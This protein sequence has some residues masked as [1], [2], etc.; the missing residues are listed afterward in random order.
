MYV[1][2]REYIDIPVDPSLA[3]KRKHQEKERWLNWTKL[4]YLK[5]HSNKAKP[6]TWCWLED[7]RKVSLDIYALHDFPLYIFHLCGI[8]TGIEGFIGEKNILNMAFITFKVR[9]KNNIFVLLYERTC[10]LQEKKDNCCSETLTFYFHQ[11]I[12]FN[13]RTFFTNKLK[14]VYHILFP[15][16]KY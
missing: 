3:L 14:H 9:E 2:G 11:Y 16:K 10:Y 12:F 4:T 15:S 13:N 1:S 7:L 6:N 5:P 8:F